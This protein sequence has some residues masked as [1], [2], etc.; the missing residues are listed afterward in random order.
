MKLLRAF[1]E[2]QGYEVE[3]TNDFKL[4]YRPEDLDP[5]GKPKPGAM[6]EMAVDNYDYKVTKKE[7]KHEK[8]DRIIEQHQRTLTGGGI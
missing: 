1:I 5:L 2:A 8:R 3:I 6:Y 4:V 7:T